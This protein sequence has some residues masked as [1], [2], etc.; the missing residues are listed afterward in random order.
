MYI[1]ILY[2]HKYIYCNPKLI[3]KK[4]TTNNADEEIYDE[5]MA[6]KSRPST[7]GPAGQ[8]AGRP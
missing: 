7:A 1:Y 2:I 5:M 4:K 8:Q 6:G 3:N